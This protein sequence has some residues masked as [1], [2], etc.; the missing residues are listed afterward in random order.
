MVLV[1]AVVVGVMIAGGCGGGCARRAICMEMGWRSGFLV[2]ANP[3]IRLRLASSAFYFASL[4]DDKFIQ[5]YIFPHQ[6]LQAISF[7][8]HLRPEY[9]H[10]HIETLHPILNLL[11]FAHKL[12]QKSPKIPHLLLNGAIL[13]LVL[14]LFLQN[15]QLPHIAMRFFLY[16]LLRSFEGDVIVFKDQ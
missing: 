12:G 2:E 6:F 13:R 3:D 8:L 5:I 1:V 11:N 7:F 4:R 14:Q 10:L 15:L 16:L 9:Q